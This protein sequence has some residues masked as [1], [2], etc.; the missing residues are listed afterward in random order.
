MGSVEANLGKIEYYIKKN[1]DKK[2]DL[3]VMPEFFATNIDYVNNAEPEDGG[4]TIK[5]VQELAKK[6]NTNIIAGSVVR[7]VNER[8][9]NTTFAINRQGEVIETYDK[10]HLFNY[11]GGSEGE[12]IEA[13]NDIKI[14]NFDFAKVGMTICFDMRYPTYVREIVRKGAQII[15]MPTAWLV[16]REIYD[17]EKLLDYAQDMFTAMCRTRAFDNMV[18]L[19]VSNQ[20]KVFCVVCHKLASFFKCVFAIKIVCINN[21]KLTFNNIFATPNCMCCAP[22]LYP[23]FWHLVTFWQIFQFL[24]NICNFYFVFNALANSFMKN[25]VIFFLNNKHNT[26]KPCTNCIKN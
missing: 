22:R 18:Y 7:E 11:M 15:V 19:V 9:Y 13:G 26:V 14:A 21:S 4:E 3:V 12:R 6:Y 20:T 16:Q 10:V 2:L 8:L 23:A 17:D 5:F 1:A 25:F 24:K